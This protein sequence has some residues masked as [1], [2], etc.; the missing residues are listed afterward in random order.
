M[1]KTVKEIIDIPVSG[2]KSNRYKRSQ[3]PLCQSSFYIMK[4]QTCF[5]QLFVLRDWLYR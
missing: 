4:F 2:L 3:A 1:S 5:R